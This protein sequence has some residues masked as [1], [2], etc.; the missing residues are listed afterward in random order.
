M[1]RAKARFN[2]PQDLA[3]RTGPLPVD[4]RISDLRARLRTFHPDHADESLNVE[5]FGHPADT[6][7]SVLVSE[8]RWAQSEID[9]NKETLYKED[10][11]AE[12]KSLATK[13]K[14]TSRFVRKYPRKAAASN[15]VLRLSLLLKHVS[16]DV[17]LL[18][19]TDTDVRECSDLIDQMRDGNIEPL[20]SAD[21]IDRLLVTVLTTSQRLGTPPRRHS[22]A[23]A[24]ATEL[25]LRIIRILED[26]G[27]R[28]SSSVFGTGEV[29]ASSPTVL[30]MKIVGD[31]LGFKFS[32]KTWSERIQS[33]LRQGARLAVTGRQFSG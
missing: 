28:T 25:T 16:R 5:V 7:A 14:A 20:I 17:D 4:P 9:W 8:V 18:L 6:F 30:C 21:A 3:D 13:L 33:A 32:E 2:R 12:L 24:I 10:V 23:Q 19:G 1:T 29:R 22:T 26:E 27:L 15:N 31:H 11:Y